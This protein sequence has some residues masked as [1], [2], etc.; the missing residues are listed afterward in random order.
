MY[1]VPE[2]L[3]ALRDFE[4]SVLEAVS[5]LDNIVYFRFAYPG[6]DGGIEIGVESEFTL[7]DSSGKVV[8]QG[9]PSFASQPFPKPPLGGTVVST[10]TRPPSAIELRFET[11]HTLEIV[12]NSDKYESFCFPHADVYI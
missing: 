8:F 5:D 7:R 4:K 3:P 10:A 9:R 12:D 2:E 11:G 6:V 1:G